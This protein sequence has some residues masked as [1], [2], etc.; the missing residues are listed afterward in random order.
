MNLHITPP[1]PYYAQPYASVYAPQQFFPAPFMPGSPMIAGPMVQPQYQNPH[2]S[3]VP[4]NPSAPKTF[5]IPAKDFVPSAEPAAAPKPKQQRERLAFVRPD[6][7][8]VVEPTKPVSVNSSPSK[9]ETPAVVEASA[10]PSAEQEPASRDKRTLEFV[11]PA[12]AVKAE[13]A[14]VESPAPVASTSADAAATIQVEEE[15]GPVEQEVDPEDLYPKEYLKTQ[16]SPFNQTGEKRYDIKFLL[17]FKKLA[18]S[19]PEDMRRDLESLMTNKGGKAN[20]DG[21]RYHSDGHHPTVRSRGK[22]IVI[23]SKV[24]V[25]P[26]EKS[27]NAWKP[28]KE[29]ELDEAKQNLSHLQ[30]HLNKIAPQT[31][32]S[33]SDQIIAVAGKLQ[34]QS[35]PEF[36]VRVFN[37]ALLQPT[38]NPMYAKLCK[39]II[40]LKTGKGEAVFPNFRKHLLDNCQR[41]FDGVTA[42]NEAFNKAKET[43]MSDDE[44]AKVMTAKRKMLG[45]IKF[46]GELYKLALLPVGIINHCIRYLLGQ[47]TEEESIECLVKL[48]DTCGEKLDE[49]QDPLAIETI[50]GYYKTIDELSHDKRLPARPRFMMQDLL[51]LRRNKWKSKRQQDVP[52]TIEAVH[53]QA[54][55]ESRRSESSREPA[56]GRTSS[57]SASSIGSL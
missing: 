5:A 34:E 7:N 16:W 44:F 22:K 46:I 53:T 37:Q 8:E 36:A 1:Q 51:D 41:E 15:T 47:S 48:L 52:S 28:L 43:S 13:P 29:Q 31:F 23:S 57:E 40:L 4:H 45:N 33:L 18:A 10:N 25:K 35:M 24:P 20:R 55:E 32:D 3:A 26:L 54:T 49:I 39:K 50:S 21:P 9:P 2:M 6:T 30:G 19:A 38:Y 56:P 42:A 17:L 11:K 12:D 27:E 14:K